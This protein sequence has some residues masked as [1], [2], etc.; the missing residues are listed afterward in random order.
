M[1]HRHTL[2]VTTNSGGAGSALTEAI[3]GYL[4]SFAY[5]KASSGAYDDGVDIDVYLNSASGQVVLAKDD[6][7]DSARF[8]PREEV[9]DTTGTAVTDV[10]CG[11]PLVNDEVLVVVASGGNA[12]TG[13]FEIVVS[14]EAP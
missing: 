14:D 5:I 3:N 1:L 12:K 11:I 8:F 13:T 6:M 9:C 10:M 4:V 7:N 2:T